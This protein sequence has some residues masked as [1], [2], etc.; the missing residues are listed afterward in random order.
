MQSPLKCLSEEN[1]T[2]ASSGTALAS[3][4]KACCFAVPFR[5]DIPHIFHA[6][7]VYGNANATMSPCMT[8]EKVHVH[9]FA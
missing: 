2:P 3:L 7:S 9:V 1:G 5:E 8:A 4:H 6:Y